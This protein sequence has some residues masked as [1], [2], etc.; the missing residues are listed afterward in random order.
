MENTLKIEFKNLLDKASEA[1]SG[2][3]FLQNL[4]DR[5]PGG[6]IFSTSF[7]YE[8]Q[9]IT[10]LIKN[11]DIDIFTLDTGRLFEQTYETWT[12]SRAFFKKEIKAWYPDPE[13]LQQFVSE[14]GPDSFYQSVEQRK[15][16]CNI[17]KVI[18]LKKALQGYKVWI[19]GLRAEHSVN[20]KN[21]P[22][23]EWDPDHEIIKY[24]PILHWTTQE[25][26]DYVKINQLPYNYLHKQGFVS[27]GCAPCTRAIKEG[28]DFR[29]GRWWWED[30]DK[31]ECGL[32]VHQ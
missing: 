31:K 23:L 19:T 5:F 28:E 18:P 11:L 9:V 25:V 13:A 14:N 32:H 21:M 29:A 17:R 4:S 3:D 8:D 16:C 6:L 15:A 30:A 10:H 7:S 27:I 24:H 20:R 1:S 26:T 22:Q 2:T 12:S